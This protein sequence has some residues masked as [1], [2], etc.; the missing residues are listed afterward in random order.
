[1]D[2]IFVLAGHGGFEGSLRHP[3]AVQPPG[4]LG[5]EIKNIVPDKQPP[6]ISVKS[7]SSIIQFFNSSIL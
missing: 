5:A 6:D 2:F 4:F 3:R 7:L 1:M